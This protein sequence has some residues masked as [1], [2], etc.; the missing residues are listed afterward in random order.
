MF[1]RAKSIAS[2]SFFTQH[3]SDFVRVCVFFVQSLTPLL[4]TCTYYAG[5]ILVCFVCH[6]TIVGFVQ[7]LLNDF[8]CS[9]NLCCVDTFFFFMFLDFLLSGGMF[10]VCWWM[11]ENFSRVVWTK[12]QDI[13]S[14]CS[15]CFTLIQFDLK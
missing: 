3:F 14:L 10:F 1:I 2:L 5:K 9:S 7:T 4:Y 8:C 13:S 11:E 6:A 15:V 12:G